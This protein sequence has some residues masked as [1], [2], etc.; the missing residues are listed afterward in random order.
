M[1]VFALRESVVGEY[2]DY[3]QSFVTILDERVAS[4]V[5]QRM[6][7]GDL[8]PDATLQ[9]NP[10]F[11]Y[12]PTLAELA[13]SGLL[14]PQT[15]RFFGPHIRLYR[16]QA[17]ALE[18]ARRG[19][20]YVVSTGTGSGKSLTYLVPIA[21]GVFR[22]RPERHTVRAV[23]VY[24]MNALINSQLRALESFRDRNWTDAPLRF[25]A[26]TGQ[27]TNEERQRILDDPPHIVLT[28]YVMLEY[29]MVRPWDRALLR[30]AT[31]ELRFLVLDELHVY[32]GR[33][34]A[35]V[36]MLVR[37]VRQRAGGTVQL[38]GTSATIATGGGHQ[39]RRAAIASVGSTL[40]GVT[41]P[42]ANVVEE[43]LRRVAA[44]PVP[45]TRAEIRA[46]VLADPPAPTAE[47]VASHPLAAWVE[48]TFGLEEREGRLIR[49]A[50]I[51]YAEGL[52]RLVDASGLDEELCR[53]RLSALLAA[54]SAARTA[55]G[56]PV[57]AFRLHQFLSSG[58]SVFATL[59]PAETRTLSADG[60]VV[61]GSAEGDEEKLFFPLA[62]CRECGQDY[63]LVELLDL[64]DRSCVVPR[65]PFIGFAVG[66]LGQPGYLAIGDDE[67]W[68][69]HAELPD[70]WYDLRAD[71]P[72]VKK[73]YR[74]FIPRRFW[75][76]P[77]GTLA[78]EPVESGL[79]VWFQP[80]PLLLCLRCRAA[81]DRRERNDYGKLATLSQVGR[82]TA[83]T[84]VT[85]VAITG[86]RAGGVEP[87]SA[88][89][90]S[91]TDNRQDAS[92]QA[93]HLNDFVQTALLRGAIVQALRKEG[94]LSF[95]RLGEA[96]FRALA[97]SP[98]QFMREA[99][100]S[101]PGYQSA[102]QAMVRLL[103]YRAFEDLRRAWR[104]AQPNLE[105]CGLLR[106]GYDGLDELAADDLWRGL[107]GIGEVDPARR[108]QALQ[109][110]LDYLRSSLVIDADCLRP[111]RIDE[112]RRLANQWLRDPWALDEFEWLPTAKVA[113]LPGAV[114]PESVDT[115]ALSARSMIGRYLR[116]RRTWD[117]VRDLSSD[118]T[119]R[120]V[121]G[122]V[123]RLRGHLLVVLS[124]G[125]EGYGVQLRAAAMRWLPG[126]GCAP[127]PDPIRARA[128]YL[129]RSEHARTEPNRYFARLYAE[130]APQLAGITAREH[131]GQVPREERI[132]RE[133]RFQSGEL[134]ALFCSPTMELGIDIADLTVVHLR[135]VP[136]T[137]ANYAQRSGRAGRSGRPALVLTFCTHGNAHDQ[138]FF[139][140]REQMIA[141]AVAPAR[142]DLTNRQLLKAHL[143]A[144]W[145]AET[146][147][148]LG[149]SM[150]EL[151]DLEREGYPLL[152][153]KRAQI[154][155]SADR[156][157]EVVRAF[158]EVLGSVAATADLSWLTET[159][160]RDVV[161]SAPR[162]L[163]AACR[164]WRELYWA[165]VRQRDE[166]RRI[167]D[168]PRVSR[169]ERAEAERRERE[170]KREIDLLR[171][172]GEAEESDFYPYRY[173]A[174]EGFLPGYNFP[175]LPLRALVTVG[176][177]SQVIQRPRFLGLT[178]FGP[179]SIIYHEGRKFQVSGCVV[180]A[181]GIQERVTRAK[182]CAVCGY[183][184]PGAD[185][186]VDVCLHCRTR[187]DGTTSEFPQHLFEQPAVRTRRRERITA[188]EE[189]RVRYGYRVT[190]HFRF[191]PGEE[192]R[193]YRVN[194]A[195]GETL[196]ELLFAPA[197]EVWRI[198]HGWRRTPQREG[199]S[200]D[201]TT[202][203]WR[204]EAEDEQSPAP[205]AAQ[206]LTGV[207]P[208]VTD[209]LNLLLVRPV[210]GAIPE[211]S[212][213][214]FV[215]TLACA[216]Q[217]G[218]EV[219]YQIEEEETAVELLGQGNHRRIL[220]YENAEGGTGV[221]E[222]LLSEPG[223][224]AEIAAEAL[225]I[226]HIDPATGA[227]EPGWAERCAA[228]CYDCLLSY[229]NQLW[230]RQIDRQLVRPFLLELATA[231]LE[232]VAAGR[233]REEHY[234]S[235]LERVDSDF[236]R[237]FLDHLHAHGLRLPD[238]AQYRPVD[239]HAQA[240]FYYER[241]GVPGIC[242]FVDGPAH[243]D[244][245]QAARDR[246][247]R[248][249]LE[250]CG[251]RVV[252]VRYD[253]PLAEQLRAHADVFGS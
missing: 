204:G 137:P 250:D 133:R 210:G 154:E 95:E 58:G 153:N 51:T 196:L 197:A 253:R 134:P 47:A 141:G 219:V 218:I 68:S 23:I 87:A 140:R 131:T 65:M 129:R 117:L 142:V 247:V 107:P 191:A 100:G 18:I 200:L 163:D 190:T 160:I 211:G 112:L 248:E 161:A 81:Y 180:P 214:R 76:R 229:A 221:W 101:G 135:N 125:G 175:A 224:L 145:L 45:R 64:D 124:L 213:E 94:T 88:K 228:A 194:R 252:V 178:E 249:E 4:F 187:L 59:E 70:S 172:E 98:E 67:L 11:E 74:P 236:E 48:E 44:G 62:F 151:L 166:A 244:P 96:I 239:L 202:G 43:T 173:L 16:H 35:D 84:T 143:H 1:D 169:E 118:E 199:F 33:R 40:F 103:E 38:I 69:E 93:G 227:D 245:Q 150:D 201:L 10:A 34:G 113:V 232:A 121:T 86:L 235:L 49:R 176:D 156:Q 152:H 147:V 139:R 186:A 127:G 55:T 144:L 205:V 159:W 36:A 105:Q 30:Q 15:A 20:P 90:L 231:E 238:H 39:E 25:A 104:V 29:L 158:Q 54:G 171:N 217:R 195:G 240:D 110:M 246:A 242:V 85:L 225:R 181:G 75:A 155:L 14:A 57:L 28:N 108:R 80:A 243:D 188:D 3:F 126:D 9:L 174:S 222:R 99:V 230:H 251:Y 82:S 42:E 146:G 157:G 212:R 165:A 120:L 83:T 50:P 234:R 53:E 148:S 122:I 233:T 184:H 132:D 177:R 27:T 31:R 168:R 198:N 179:G 61:A 8:W 119:E 237:E 92:L 77:D 91:F 193:R 26:Y 182:I 32:G 220:F 123:E 189:E 149:R 207:K 115:I 241:E 21:D 5:E 128:L 138:Y 12:G 52:R 216:L 185:A 226:C 56:E 13:A 130:R 109:A 19:E 136:P 102:R 164:R 170:A 17:E 66:E 22:D 63:Y 6:E 183:I 162:T 206:V 97:L 79:A 89:V 78:I 192:P 41:V 106:I 24:P 37:R 73:E 223:S 7:G 167:I 114:A 111:E 215:A 46:A 209:T 2:R 208:Y 60:Q 71:G 203:Q 116:S 72:R